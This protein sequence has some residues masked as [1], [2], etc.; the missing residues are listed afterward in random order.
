MMPAKA[1]RDGKKLALTI[2]VGVFIAIMLI[3]LANLIVSYAYNAPEYDTYCNQS[4]YS[5]PQAY[6]NIATNCTFNKTLNDQAN[7]C[8]SQ[9]GMP[10]YEYDNNGCLTGLSSCN[11]CSN[12]FNDATAR[13]NMISFFIFAIVGFALIV[14]GLFIPTLLIQIIALPAGAILV[15]EAAV[16]N[17]SDKLSVIIVLALLVVAAIYLSLKKLK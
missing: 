17:F 9:G 4:V 6:P 3:T 13:Y 16:K 10:V 8:T 15:I 2:I 5:Y 7:S 11:L 1:I 14:A 12:Q